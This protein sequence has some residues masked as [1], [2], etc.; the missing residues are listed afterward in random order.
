[1]QGTVQC[2]GILFI[3]ICNPIVHFPL[4]NLISMVSLHYSGVVVIN[5]LIG[6]NAVRYHYCL[7]FEQSTPYPSGGSGL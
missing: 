2:T 5:R 7:G 3:I 1:M 6:L 4:H